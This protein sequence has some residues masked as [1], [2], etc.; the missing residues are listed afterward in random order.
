MIFP[1]TRRELFFCGLF[2]YWGEGTKTAEA[3]LAI[4]NTDPSMIKFFIFWLGRIFRVPKKKLRI[5][6]HLY[7]DM[8][9]DKETK[10]WSD[11]TKISISQFRRPYI[12]KTMKSAINYKRG[13]GHGTCNVIIGDARL[14][15]KVLMSIKAL[16]VHYLGV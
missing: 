4:A 5:Y 12:K 3:R 1:L 15:E 16:S 2:L 9:L 8:D 13:F 10:Y 14:S 7:K 6:L 11:I